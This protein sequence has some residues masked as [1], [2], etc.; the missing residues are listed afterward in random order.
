MKV[1]LLKDVERV[2]IAGEVIK[3]TEGYGLNFLIPRKL[4]VAVNKSNETFYEKNAKKVE[5]R[6]DAIASKTSLLAEKIKETVVTLKRKMHNDGKLYG[7]INAIEIV[8]AL[9]LEGVVASKSQIFFDKTIKEKGVF[10]V[11]VKLTSSLQPKLK[12]KII[13]EHAAN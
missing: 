6:K 1:Y 13:P 5:H 10:D 7:S 8:D 12:V 2:G 9:A 11:T 3:V 4:A